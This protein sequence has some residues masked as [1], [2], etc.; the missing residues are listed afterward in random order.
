MDQATAIRV[1][2][3]YLEHLKKKNFFICQAY[4]FGSYSSGQQNENSDIDLAIVMNR[5]INS[6]T[7]QVEL[8]KISRKFDTRIEPHPFEESEFNG[9]NPLANEILNTGI[10]I[11]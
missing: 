7:T 5:L 6:F 11:I 8:I 4:L 3:Q 10:R 9:A 1:L 2:N